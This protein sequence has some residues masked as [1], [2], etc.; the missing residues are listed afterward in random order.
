MRAAGLDASLLHRRDGE[1]PNQGLGL[2]VVGGFGCGGGNNQPHHLFDFE[3][4]A[5]IGFIL[6]D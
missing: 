3:E 1:N 5:D 2:D 6:D 4:G